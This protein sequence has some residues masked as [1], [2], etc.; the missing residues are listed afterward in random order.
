MRLPV[1]FWDSRF[2]TVP[3]GRTTPKRNADMREAVDQL[4]YS[5]LVAEVESVRASLPKRWMHALSRFAPTAIG[6][7]R[8]T[9]RRRTKQLTRSH[10]SW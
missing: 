3:P 8:V 10:R 4:I 2:A 1:G 5:A 9:G 6:L 7:A